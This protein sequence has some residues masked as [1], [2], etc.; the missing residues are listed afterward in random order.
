MKVSGSDN[1]DN[2]EF[3]IYCAITQRQGLSYRSECHDC[4]HSE[5]DYRLSN[6][7]LFHSAISCSKIS[8]SFD[9][10]PAELPI[11]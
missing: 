10:P 1:R 6:F 9:D 8:E 5:T 11:R 2:L 7:R 4:V 3:S